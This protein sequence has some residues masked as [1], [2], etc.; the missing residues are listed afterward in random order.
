MPFERK[1]DLSV[2]ADDLLVD[3]D[4]ACM[5][6]AV[7]M[8]FGHRLFSSFQDMKDHQ[9]SL[10]MRCV[11]KDRHFDLDSIRNIRFKNHV[12]R[13][14]LLASS[15]LVSQA[16]FFKVLS[17][18]SILLVNYNIPPDSKID[19]DALRDSKKSLLGSI[20]SSSSLNIPLSAEESDPTC[21]RNIAMN[22]NADGTW[23]HI[24]C[25]VKFDGKWVQRK[26]IDCSFLPFTDLDLSNYLVYALNDP[27]VYKLQLFK[28]SHYNN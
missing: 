4:D 12:F 22:M 18:E 24:E 6:T 10:G 1:A 21:M 25:F 19:V 11:H 28:Y 20:G 3:E 8:Y 17:Q 23:G 2:I 26:Q 7:N 27:L 9:A 15:H 13:L 5:A 16:A 14:R